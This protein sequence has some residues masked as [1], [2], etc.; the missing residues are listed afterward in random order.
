MSIYR[1]SSKKV[2][3]VKNK[4]ENNMQTEGYVSNTGKHRFFHQ[5][6]NIKNTALIVFKRL[7][8]Q[9]KKRKL[10]EKKIIR[11]SMGQ[12][13]NKTR[14]QNF[15]TTRWQTYVSKLGK[16]GFDV[17]IFHLRRQTSNKD[18]ATL[19]FGFFGFDFLVVD[20]MVTF[21]NDLSA[22]NQA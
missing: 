13:V 3:L 8:R 10:R 9:M 7:S 5:L 16:V 4:Q 19:G 11:H 22:E 12:K 1:T 18:L 17:F 15:T 6:L 21:S 20:H 14:R 2:L